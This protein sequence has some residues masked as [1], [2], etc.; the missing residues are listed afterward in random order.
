MSGLEEVIEVARDLPE[1]L[2]PEVG[3]EPTRP[4]KVTGF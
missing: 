4:V 2:V 3:I 1:R